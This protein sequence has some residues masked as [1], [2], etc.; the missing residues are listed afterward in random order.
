MTKICS[1]EAII[2]IIALIYGFGFGLML[3]YLH[4]FVLGWARMVLNLDRDAIIS[5]MLHLFIE[6]HPGN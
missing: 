6:L 2:K 5:G 1:Y 4:S 3:W